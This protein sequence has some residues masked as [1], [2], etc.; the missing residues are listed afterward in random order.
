MEAT[1]TLDN[2]LRA[3]GPTGL[4]VTA[5]CIGGSPLGSVPSKYGEVSEAAA[6]EFV[7]AVLASPIRFIDTAN[8]YSD[9]ESERRIGAAI[10][11][12]GGLPDDFLVATK[13]DALDGDY[14]GDRVRRS[15]RESKERLGLDRLPLVY[16]HDPEYHDYSVLAAP[17]GA[18]STLVEL[19]ESGEIGHV[20]LAGGHVDVMN[21]YLD[22][23]VFEVL[24][25]HSR[26][27]LVDHSAHQLIERAHAAGLG[28]VNAAVNG[29]GILAD[30][31]S[32]R[33]SY[34]YRPAAPEVLTAVEAIAH[35]CDE[36][37]VPLA[38]AALQW[39]LRDTRIHSTVVGATKAS[40]LD[41]IMKAV[42][43]ELPE[44]FWNAAAEL[45]P[46]A[47]RWLDAETVK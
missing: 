14:S 40:R 13:V 21:R 30:A 22:L 43:T 42:K 12:A 37:G 38:T 7:Q 2:W 34:G 15:V 8:G 46:P 29:G 16:L 36:A 5:V 18:V 17:G 26:W 10:S 31:R 27:T 47:E 19:K 45:L 28:I 6:I 11:A 39:S 3:L 41:D 4:N 25:T 1:T 24:L 33:T 23:E 20:G 32:G 44:S 9:G 35:L